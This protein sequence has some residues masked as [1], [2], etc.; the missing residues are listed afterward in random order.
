MAGAAITI[1]QCVD[2][3]EEEGRIVIEP[4]GPP[5]YDLDLM[6]DQMDP[7]QFPE[8]ADFGPPQGEEIW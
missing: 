1:D 3:R 7:A 5:P 4:V 8:E 6:I 2:V